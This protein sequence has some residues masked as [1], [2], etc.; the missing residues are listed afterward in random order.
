MKL[1]PATFI[2]ADISALPGFLKFTIHMLLF[3]I[4]FLVITNNAIFD[5][6]QRDKW[7]WTLQQNELFM[8][9]EKIKHRSIFDRPDEAS[10]S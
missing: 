2:I 6:V 3:K 8:D 5:I 4:S 9:I 10:G 1:W 7:S